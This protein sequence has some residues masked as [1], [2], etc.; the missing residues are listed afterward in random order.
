MGKKTL[1]PKV[2]QSIRRPGGP[3]AKHLMELDSNM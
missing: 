2:R 1:A 3:K